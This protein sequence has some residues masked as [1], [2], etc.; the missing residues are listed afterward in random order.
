[1]LSVTSLAGLFGSGICISSKF[2]E[3]EY[4]VKS[5][6]LSIF[7]YVSFFMRTSIIGIAPHTHQAKKTDHPQNDKMSF[8][9]IRR[10]S[11]EGCKVLT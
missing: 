9:V 6:F 4:E 8:G 2:I 7:S 10:C 1:L 5:G 3:S 11:G